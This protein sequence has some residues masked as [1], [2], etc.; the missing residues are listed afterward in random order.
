MNV[1]P[2]VVHGEGLAVDVCRVQ[3]YLCAHTDHVPHNMLVLTG[4]ESRQVSEQAPVDAVHHVASGESR[5]VWTQ[6]FLAQFGIFA[7]FQ[8]LVNV[9]AQALVVYLVQHDEVVFYVL[10]R[11]V[12]VKDSCKIQLERRCSRPFETKF[13][14]R[15]DDLHW[16]RYP[17]IC[18]R[19]PSSTAKSW[20]L[21]R[22][23]EDQSNIPII[24]QGL[25]KNM[26]KITPELW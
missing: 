23:C 6:E 1:I 7:F 3:I 14:T 15:R 5:I 13:G 22:N 8:V 2:V 18:W 24:M 19:F 10:S 16:C 21:L 4:L 20:F 9:P 11:V 26:S 25:S 17:I 12:I